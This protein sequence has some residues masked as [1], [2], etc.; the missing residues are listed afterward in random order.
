[1]PGNPG[2]RGEKGIPGQPGTRGKEGMPGRQGDI[3]LKVKSEQCMH[4]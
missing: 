4:R 2:M 3:G 1:M